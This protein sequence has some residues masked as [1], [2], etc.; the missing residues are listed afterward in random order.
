MDIVDKL[1]EKA[2]DMDLTPIYDAF[3]QPAEEEGAE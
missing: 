2:K 3:G 1:V